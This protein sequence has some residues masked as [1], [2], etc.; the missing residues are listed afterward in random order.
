M[1]PQSPEAKAAEKQR[2]MWLI[3]GVAAV[4]VSLGLCLAGRHRDP[5]LTVAAI[6][7]R[8]LGLFGREDA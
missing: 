4:L 7:Q 3:L 2:M 1:E 6:R 5:K 8:L